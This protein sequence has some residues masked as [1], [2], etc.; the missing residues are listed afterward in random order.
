M[1][2]LYSRKLYIYLSFFWLRTSKISLLHVSAQVV[3][4][5]K[6]QVS[7]ADSMSCSLFQG[8]RKCQMF[9]MTQKEEADFEF[10]NQGNS[11]SA[12]CRGPEVEEG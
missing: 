12:A 3:I 4:Q 5:S 10:M 1:L 7:Q 9:N 2:Q 11:F 8:E 6:L